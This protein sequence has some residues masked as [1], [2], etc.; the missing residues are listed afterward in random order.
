[1][2]GLRRDTIPEDDYRPLDMG[3]DARLEGKH[4]DGNPYPTTNWKHYEWDKG[5]VMADE[6]AEGAPEIH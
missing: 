3:W 6:T 1:M 5:W 2:T 4:M